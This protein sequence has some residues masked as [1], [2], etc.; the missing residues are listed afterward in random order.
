MYLQ[1]NAEL[2]FAFV[3]LLIPDAKSQ[4]WRYKQMFIFSIVAVQI[5]FLNFLTLD[6]SYSNGA[7]NDYHIAITF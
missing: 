4:H 2:N 1:V 6:P 7:V 3:D 5:N